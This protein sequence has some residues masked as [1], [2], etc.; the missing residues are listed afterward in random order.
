MNISNA[1]FC[2]ALGSDLLLLNIF[3]VDAPVVLG[4]PETA[5]GEVVRE[6]KRLTG[7]KMVAINLEPVPEN[8]VSEDLD[9][10][11]KIAPGRKA[12]VEN[13]VRAAEMGVDMV[14]LTGNPGNGV[15][16]GAI[17]KTLKE[18]KAATGD[19]LVLGAGKMHASEVLAESGENIITAADVDEFINAGADIILM[20][21]PGTVPG[22]TA[23]YAHM[24]IS[25]VHARN[26]LAMT[27]IG[28]SQ[29]G[30]DTETIRSI[31]L[32]CKMAGADIHH[33][34]DSAYCGMAMP[35]DI[36]AYSVAIRGRRHTYRRMAMSINR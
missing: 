26:K 35:E 34:G 11:W 27:A 28:T 24:L 17:V 23:D 4:L 13:A 31:A 12:T 33:L 3:D 16:N 29:E 36:T 22:I 14:L 18:I 2:A 8:L 9:N 15:N 1:E 10:A 20:P 21:A 30:A 32:M 7:N 6:I 25:K 5:P 19:R